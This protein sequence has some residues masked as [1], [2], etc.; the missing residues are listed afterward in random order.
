M[1]KGIIFD[2]DGVLIDSEHIN[3]TAGIQAFKEFGYDLSNADKKLIPGQHSENVISQILKLRGLDLPKEAL[4]E[5]YSK[6]YGDMW[7][8]AVTVMPQAKETLQRLKSGGITLGLATNNYR[9]RVE[10]FLKQTELGNIFSVIVSGEDV[11]KRKPDPEVYVRAKIKLGLP[12]ESIL[13]IEDGAVGLASAKGAGLR[14]AIIL[15][16]YS[17]GQDFSN[18]DFVF[19]SL[20][21]LINHLSENKLMDKIF[22]PA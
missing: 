14:C 20:A 9:S 22:L 17:A 15:N 1:I 16:Q 21:E 18:A 8:D 13:A 4:R 11:A 19:K 6:A 7:E 2:F 12:D 3:I 10:T 5:Q